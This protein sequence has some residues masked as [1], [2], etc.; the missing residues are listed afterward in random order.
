MI[1][2]RPAGPTPAA[3]ATDGHGRP[4]PGG[5]GGARP[6]APRRR[7]GPAP[8][9]RLLVSIAACVMGAMVVTVSAQYARTYTLARR[10]AQL[11]QHRRDLIAQNE[12]LRE[13]IHRLRTDDRYIELLA[14]RQLGLVRP[15]EIELLLVPAA[16]PSPP[17]EAG[18]PDPAQGDRPGAQERGAAGQQAGAGAGQGPGLGP[19]A[20]RLE[21]AVEHLFGWIRQRVSR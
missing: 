18:T 20:A 9:H 5:E 7:R 21:A 2:R 13:E 19:W 6:P 17:G 11:D 1:P 15:G 12:R 16:P 10:A 8:L 14:R 3:S 4:A